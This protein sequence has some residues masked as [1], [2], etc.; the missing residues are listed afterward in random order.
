MFWFAGVAT[1]ERRVMEA[2]GDTRELSWRFEYCR[3]YGAGCEETHHSFS[4]SFGN[5]VVTSCLMSTQAMSEY[6]LSC[7]DAVMSGYAS[8]ALMMNAQARDI[9]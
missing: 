5:I 8:V 2:I 9:N 1:G 4:F 3:F 6:H 7:G